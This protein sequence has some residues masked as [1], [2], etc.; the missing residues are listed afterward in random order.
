MRKIFEIDIRQGRT[1]YTYQGDRS[2]ATEFGE[3]LKKTET[4]NQNRA[5]NIAIVFIAAG[6]IGAIVFSILSVM[7]GK[8]STLNLITLW[9]YGGFISFIAIYANSSRVGLGI[10][11]CVL[12]ILVSIFIMVKGN[13]ANSIETKTS[14]FAALPIWLSVVLVAISFKTDVEFSRAWKYFCLVCQLLEVC[15]LSC[16]II[17]SGGIRIFG[18]AI[19]I[20]A[21]MLL[22]ACGILAL[23]GYNYL[24]SLL[25]SSRVSIHYTMDAERRK[26]YEN[27]ISV[28]QLLIVDRKFSVGGR[29]AVIRNA[30]RFYS[31]KSNIAVAQ[32]WG[33]NASG[34]MKL[35]ALLPDIV[36]ENYLF[37]A[38]VD[39]SELKPIFSTETAESTN[40]PRNARIVGETWKY[41][42]KD[43]TRDLRYSESK[44]P[45]I[46]R[47]LYCIIECAQGI[48]ELK[49]TNYDFMHDFCQ[50]LSQYGGIPMIERT[51]SDSFI[52]SEVYVG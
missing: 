42:K 35:I 4:Q 25:F 34:K 13:L 28:A 43:G 36:W 50:E 32:I 20:A 52:D 33:H 49:G 48:P 22:F 15:S 29:R 9:L 26:Q 16:A 21:M 6:L 47:F 39:Y 38:A 10:G 3:I 31:F 24:F 46:V 45:T 37:G 1:Q 19:A 12:C 51:S 30:C 18:F 14:L 17:L 2:N 23:C 27:L 41:T 11:E 7:Y 44:N 8:I 40:P 5:R